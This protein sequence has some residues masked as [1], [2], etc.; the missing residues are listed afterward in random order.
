MGRGLASP[1]SNAQSSSPGQAAELHK[2]ETTQRSRE[3][4]VPA[5]RPRQKPPQPP[6]E[7]P[8]PFSLALQPNP[9]VEQDPAQE[10][11]HRLVP[12][13]AVL[14]HHRTGLAPAPGHQTNAQPGP[15]AL[16]PSHQPGGLT[17]QTPG[18]ARGCR[19]RARCPAQARRGAARQPPLGRQHTGPGNG[20]TSPAAPADPKAPLQPHAKGQ[21]ISQN[22][23]Q[24]QKDKLFSPPRRFLPSHSQAPSLG[25][26]STDHRRGC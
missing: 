12:A 17:L 13:T 9:S 8:S 20:Q 4:Q 2:H 26:H 6:S 23:Y 24:H 5:A 16:S 10:N 11:K 18:C 25:P 7:T 22:H 1:P 15:A 21:G 3:Q 19:G 14:C